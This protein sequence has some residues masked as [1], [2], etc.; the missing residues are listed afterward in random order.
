MGDKGIY[1]ARCSTDAQKNDDDDDNM[2]GTVDR[3]HQKREE[4]FLKLDQQSDDSDSEEESEKE[5]VMDLGLG[6]GGDQSSSSDDSSI[7]DEMKDRSDDQDEHSSDNEDEQELSEDS[8]DDEEFKVENVRDWGKKKTAYYYGDTADLEIGQDEEDAYLEEQAAKEVQAARYQ[9]MSEDDFVFS[10]KEEDVEGD[11][12]SKH[13]AQHIESSTR[14]VSK[15]SAK[16]RR[17]ILDKK[18]PEMLPLLSYFSEVVKE[19][20]DSTS[21]ATRAIFQGEEGTAEVGWWFTCICSHALHDGEY[22]LFVRLS[23]HP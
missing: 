21:V 3:Y 6:G 18:H 4:E 15:L 11:E 23:A 8:G 20:E 19:L 2:Y 10:D 22:V 1:K 17:K 14:D 12:D 9:D 16:D 7:E 13:G 5:A